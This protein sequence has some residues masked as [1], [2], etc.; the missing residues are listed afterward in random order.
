MFPF[1]DRTIQELLCSNF[2]QLRIRIF[3]QIFETHQRN[4]GMMGKKSS[5]SCF[6][7]YDTIGEQVILSKALLISK[8]IK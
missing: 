5:E 8:C 2:I 6:F 1:G 3:C 7:I 4:V